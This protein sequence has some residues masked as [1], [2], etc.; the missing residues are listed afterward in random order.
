LEG[1]SRFPMQIR[2]ELPN[3]T[4]GRSTS[5]GVV[6][7][8]K[9]PARKGKRVVCVCLLQGMRCPADEVR[10]PLGRTTV[11]PVQYELTEPHRGAKNRNNSLLRTTTYVRW[12]NFSFS[13]AQRSCFPG[14]FLSGLTSGEVPVQQL[15]EDPRPRGL[16][17]EGFRAGSVASSGAGY[18]LV[19]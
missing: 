15:T 18:C 19:G 1:F 4:P 14:L 12:R 5:Y 2:G 8:L 16:G 7:K 3:L 17:C 13:A 6:M 10:L 9:A 11:L